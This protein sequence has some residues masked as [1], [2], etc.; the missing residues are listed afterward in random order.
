MKT[1]FIL[2]VIFFVT[3]V[4]AVTVMIHMFLW[5]NYDLFFAY[6]RSWSRFVLKI[7][8]VR[9]TTQG[10]ELLAP[11]ERFVY[12]ANH[13]SLF[14]IPVILAHVPDNVR[15]MYKRELEKIPIFGWC[16]RMS[17]FIAID[18]DRGRDASDVLQSTVETL[19]CGSSVLIFP[20]G[21]RSDDGHVGM[22]RRGAFTLAARS[23]RPI[24]ALSLIGTA[25]ILPKKTRHIRG[26][27]VILHIDAPVLVPAELSREEERDLMARVR[28]IIVNTVDS[29]L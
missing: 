16:V 9:V 12:V 2:V 24:V 13:A 19:R 14:D 27:N 17:P 11:G 25:S 18:R 7:S 8:G 29:H 3:A 22:F 15:I 23:G 26:G 4:Y 5:K 21:T 20:E 6:T 10:A 1:W 28:Q